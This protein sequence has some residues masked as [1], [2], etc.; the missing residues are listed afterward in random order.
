MDGAMAAAEP[1]HPSDSLPPPLRRRP[2]RLVFDRRYGWIF[3]EWTDPADQALSGGRGISCLWTV[4]ATVDNWIRKLLV[5]EYQINI[6]A[7]S[8]S[9][10]LEHPECFPLPA[11]V[12]SLTF[13]KKQQAAWIRELEHSGI[14]ADCKLINC[15]L[16]SPVECTTADCI[17]VTK[18]HDCL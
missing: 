1:E 14:V 11:H 12:S 16:H 10:V 18:Q 8:I 7:T 15:C 3:D 9:R 13:H 6:A 5:S 17:C 4:L 2:R